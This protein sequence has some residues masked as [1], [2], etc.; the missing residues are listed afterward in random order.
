M[1]RQEFGLYSRGEQIRQYVMRHGLKRWCAIDDDYQGWPEHYLPRF[2]Q[3][4]D[5]TGLSSVEVQ[6][7]LRIVLA[8]L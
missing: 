7:R 2:I 3:T 5:D 8:S 6:N 1:S 4:D